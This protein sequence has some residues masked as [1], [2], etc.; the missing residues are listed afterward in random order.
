MRVVAGCN[1]KISDSFEVKNPTQY[2]ALIV[3]ADGNNFPNSGP[4]LYLYPCISASLTLKAKLTFT[5]Q[6]V[7]QTVPDAELAAYSFQWTYNG[8]PI[9]GATGSTFIVTSSRSGGSYRY[10]ATAPTCSDPINSYTNANVY[11]SFFCQ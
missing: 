9:P 7:T 8:N 3:G 4:N 5:V 11:P 10:S 1:S 2:T 6:G